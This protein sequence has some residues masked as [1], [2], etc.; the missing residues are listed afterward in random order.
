[1]PTALL[2]AE[3]EAGALGH[4]R[5]P[6]QLSR[7]SAT[8]Y[9]NHWQRYCLPPPAIPHT[10]PNFSWTGAV[11]IARPRGD[12]PGAGPRQPGW[13]QRFPR[14]A[15]PREVCV[16]ALTAPNSCG[17]KTKKG[18]MLTKR[19]RFVFALLLLLSWPFQKEILLLPVILYC[20]KEGKKGLQSNP[21]A[22]LA[23]L[24]PNSYAL[25]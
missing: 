20:Y 14:A 9:G 21:N 24:F 16:F 3:P 10:R 4:A 15:A 22:H 25:N 2:A 13:R 7:P 18:P 19:K 5:V 17:G 8:C 1:M 11:V 23:D 12:S 6:S